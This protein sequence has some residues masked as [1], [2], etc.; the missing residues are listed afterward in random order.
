MMIFYPRIF[1]RNKMIKINLMQMEYIKF[2]PY[3]QINIYQNEQKNK[4]FKLI[5]ELNHHKK[6]PSNNTHRKRNVQQSDAASATGKFGALC[7][8]QF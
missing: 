1:I 3:N 7:K 2:M 6:W 8:N 5:Y 4:Y